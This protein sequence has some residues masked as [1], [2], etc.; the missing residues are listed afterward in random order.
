[1]AMKAARMEHPLSGFSEH[2]GN[3]THLCAVPQLYA[4][5]KLKQQ[6]YL[7][8][9]RCDFWIK[10]LILNVLRT[11]G[12]CFQFSLVLHKDIWTKQGHCAQRIIKVVEEDAEKRHTISFPIQT[13]GY[14]FLQKYWKN[15][16]FDLHC[17]SLKIVQ[18]RSGG[19]LK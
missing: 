9:T 16:L 8:D 2:R 3:V 13:L 17:K 19:A 11:M 5:S 6:A 10:L 7:T 4:Y 18:Q 14:L 15:I 12:Q 1:M